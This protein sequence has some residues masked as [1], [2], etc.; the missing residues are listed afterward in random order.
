MKQ[1]FGLPDNDDFISVLVAFEAEAADDVVAFLGSDD[2]LIVFNV[3]LLYPVVE[4]EIWIVDNCASPFVG[5]V[6]ALWL[7]DFIARGY[8][9]RKS[10]VLM[11]KLIYFKAGG[12]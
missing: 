7:A 11:A 4:V 8:G 1:F 5:K 3:E 12:A 6:A 10:E 9:I 2:A